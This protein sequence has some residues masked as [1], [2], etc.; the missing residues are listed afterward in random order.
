M[1]P[2]SS[3]PAECGP[4]IV[5]F[6]S[7]DALRSRR[8]GGV[9]LA[10][11]VDVPMPPARLTADWEREVASVLHLEPGDVEPLPLPRARLRWP[12]YRRCVQAMA[13][14]T[15]ARG[16]PSVLDAGEIALMACRGANYHHDAAQ[17]GGVAFCNLFL[18]E[19]KGL[20]LHFPQVGLRM[21]LTRGTAVVFD[22][23]QPHAVL[24]RGRSGFD[25]ADFADGADVTA[26]FLSWEL[27]IEHGHVARALG[28]VF[29]GDL[30]AV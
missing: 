26:V 29:D 10:G 9:V 6:H 11:T 15:A 18:S 12:D 19:D 17:Y 7:G 16:L 23:G 27:P 2:D 21:P 1:H 20:D 14:W 30:P 4:A 5:R 24:R 3:S 28:V 22:T 25:A 8:V 13:D